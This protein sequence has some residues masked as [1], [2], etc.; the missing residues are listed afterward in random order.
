MKAI[1]VIG[2]LYRLPGFIGEKHGEMKF[3]SGAAALHFAVF[4]DYALQVETQ[5]FYWVWQ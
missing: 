3:I 5:L 4:W 1:D 2:L